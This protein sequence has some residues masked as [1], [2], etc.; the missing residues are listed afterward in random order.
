MLF[1]GVPLLMVRAHTC[2]AMFLI[3]D[4]PSPSSQLALSALDPSIAEAKKAKK[5]PKVT[6]HVYFDISIGG[7]EF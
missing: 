6:H 5:G 7:G 1:K 3:Y 4:L 2:Y